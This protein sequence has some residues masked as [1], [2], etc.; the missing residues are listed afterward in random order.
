[1]TIGEFKDFIKENNLSDNTRMGVLDLTTD[2]PH[3]AN[4]GI[5]KN[6]IEILEC[7]SV[8]ELETKKVKTTKGVF[9]GF[10]NVLNANPL[11]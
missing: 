4:Y 11:V 5:T 2:D 1:M 7:A 10:N 8:D 9:F 3:D 6:S